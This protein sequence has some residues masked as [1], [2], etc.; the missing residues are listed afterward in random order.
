MLSYCSRSLSLS[1][2]EE[3]AYRGVVERG[4]GNAGDD[5]EQSVVVVVVCLFFLSLSFLLFSSFL[6]SHL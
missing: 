6:S 5:D 2:E 4:R 3:E 1:T